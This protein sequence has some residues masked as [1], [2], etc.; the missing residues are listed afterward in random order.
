[1]SKRISLLLLLVVAPLGAQQTSGAIDLGPAFAAERRGAYPEAGRLYKEALQQ[2][3]TNLAALLGLERIAEALSEVDSVLVYVNRALEF[4]NSQP[5][6]RAIQ[7]RTLGRLGMDE[8][9]ENAASSWMRQSPGNPDPYREWASALQARGEMSRAEEILE[10]GVEEL[11]PGRLG[12]ELA[13]VRIQLGRWSDATRFWADEVRDDITRVQAAVLTLSA[14]PGDARNGVVS[15][16][17]ELG[18]KDP[19]QL[20][21]ADLLVQWSRPVEGWVLLDRALPNDDR[22]A[23]GLLRRFVDRTE[24]VRGRESAR[25]RGLA[26]EAIADLTDGALSQGARLDAARAFSEAGDQ[27]SAERMLERVA[28]ETGS[29]SPQ[30]AGAMTGLIRVKAENGEVAE[31]EE[32]FMEWQNRLRIEDR[33]ALTEA[34]VWGWIKEDS[35]ARARTLLGTDSSI[36]TMAMRGWIALFEGDLK[37]AGDAFRI[38]GPRAGTRGDATRRTEVLAIIQRVEQDTVFDLGRGLHQ[39]MIGDTTTAITLLERAAAHLPANEGGAEISLEAGRVAY[40]SID[41]GRAEEILSGALTRD[42]SGPAAPAVEM[43]LAR[44]Y[45]ATG[46]RELAVAS[47]EEVILQHPESAV[48]PRARRLLDEL[49]GAVP[50]S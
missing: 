20:V 1:M 44:T 26:L 17:S 27:A 36:T 30:Q 40:E 14:T 25:A 5:F 7:L 10:A 32:R 42:A 11:G 46:R 28:V 19:A 15:V 50:S 22:L 18:G 8:E 47:I 16:L 24:Q 43:L 37:G 41:Y 39:L 38:A 12:E 3:S 31:A 21:A 23:L 49:R 4:N 33:Q 13:R 6:V 35:L 45:M 34:L 29:V 48:V 2:E 9:L